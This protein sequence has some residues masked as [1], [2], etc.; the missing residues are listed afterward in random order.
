M[1][2]AKRKLLI[3]AAQAYLQEMDL[4]DAPARFDVIEVYL[5]TDL[6]HHIENAFDTSGW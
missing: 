5:G 1:T 3:Q 4:L 2:P 6:I